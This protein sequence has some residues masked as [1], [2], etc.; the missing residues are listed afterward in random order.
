KVALPER[1][2]GSSSD[3]PPFIP[4][5]RGEENP[6]NRGFADFPLVW[7]VRFRF[8]PP[9]TGRT[10]GKIATEDAHAYPRRLASRPSQPLGGRRGRRRE[11]AAGHRGRLRAGAPT[12]SRAL[13]RRDPRQPAAR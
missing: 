11:P 6:P 7:K 4:K 13:G 8:A 12:L 9:P 3:T 10:A 5:Q 1:T 2:T